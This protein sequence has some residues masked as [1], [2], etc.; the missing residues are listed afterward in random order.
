MSVVKII[1][2]IAEGNSI[3]NAIENGLERASET[4]EGIQNIWV[5]DVKAQ[6]ENNKIS[7]YRLILK[8][9]FILNK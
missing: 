2:I 6:V 9:S 7:T 1:E 8:V 4:V 5:K 3:E